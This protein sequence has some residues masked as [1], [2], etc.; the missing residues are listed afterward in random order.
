[1]SSIKDHNG[2][3]VTHGRMAVNGVRLHYVTA[4][5]G[6]PLLLVHGVPKSSYYWHR[7]IPLLTPHYKVI[8]PDVRGFGD[9][10]RPAGGYDMATIATDLAEL[11]TQLG[12]QTFYLHGEDWGA[13]FSYALAASY[14]DRI[15]KFSY[16]EMLLPGFGLEK[17]SNL[18]ADN[19]F[20]N[21]FLW[22]VSF[23][24]VPDFPEM[25]I[26]GRER[27][28]WETW[29]KNETYDPSAITPDCVDEWARTSSA[30]GGLRAIFQV[31]RETFK[32]IEDDK[33][34]A[35]TKLA[36]P[37]MAV[38][39]EY[40]IGEENKRQMERVAESVEY[41]QLDCGHSMALERPQ[42]LADTLKSFFKD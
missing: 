20:S 39:S 31:Y 28:F 9:S 22:H 15:K 11:M 37:V 21:H 16:G 40:F 18:E 23:F 6:E 32:N 13:A 42:L 38:G 34:W 35:E 7:I 29:M 10:F 8:A 2:N 17:W 41:V 25:L 3:E 24:H 5:E 33:R 14:R 19:V 4:G 1:M 30:P 26:T 12:H 27:A 36:M